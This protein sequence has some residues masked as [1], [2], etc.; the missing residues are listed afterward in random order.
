[1]VHGQDLVSYSKLFSDRNDIATPLDSNF[2]RIL[3][4]LFAEI[5][6]AK[7]RESD[8]KIAV[9]FASTNASTAVK[10]WRGIQYSCG[11]HGLVRLPP[12]PPGN[13]ETALGRFFVASSN[14]PSG[15]VFLRPRSYS[16]AMEKPR[17][18][19][20]SEDAKLMPQLGRRYAAASMYVSVAVEVGGRHI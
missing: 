1:M 13:K 12:L 11:F 2:D 8:M 15:A 5:G 6:S 4:A 16:N 17:Q 9:F 20:A 19:E 14:R 3:R 7:R 18:F 10:D